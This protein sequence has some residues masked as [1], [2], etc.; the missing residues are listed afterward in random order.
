M[1]SPLLDWGPVET[2]PNL[3]PENLVSPAVFAIMAK[4]KA[5]TLNPHALGSSVQRFFN[6]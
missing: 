2:I 3:I 1:A 6:I 5:P 4:T